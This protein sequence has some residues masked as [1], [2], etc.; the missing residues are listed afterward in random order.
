[1][2]EEQFSQPEIT[3]LA[4]QQGNGQSFFDRVD[5]EIKQYKE[6]MNQREK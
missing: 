2:I 3:E 4:R 1:M 6:K 5:D